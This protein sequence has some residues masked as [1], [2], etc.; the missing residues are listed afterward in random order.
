MPP[1]YLCAVCGTLALPINSNLIDGRRFVHRACRD[2]ILDTD[3]DWD[4]E[5]EEV[6]R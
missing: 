2:R 5:I 6:A 1:S 3:P 4:D